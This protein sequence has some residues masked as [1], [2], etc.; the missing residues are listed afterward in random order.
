MPQKQNKNTYVLLTDYPFQIYAA[1]KL[2]L[3]CTN[4]FLNRGRDRLSV[5]M[6]RVVNKWMDAKVLLSKSSS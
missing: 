3:H 5:G 6:D 2:K 4:F 1:V